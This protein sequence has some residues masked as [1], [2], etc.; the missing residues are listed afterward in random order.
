MVGDA[1]GNINIAEKKKEILE[2]IVDIYYEVYFFD[3]DE[4]N[5]SLAK[6]IP[7]IKTR[8]VESDI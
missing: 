5:I 2:R 1:V 4:N 7:G 8:L 3:D 6:Q